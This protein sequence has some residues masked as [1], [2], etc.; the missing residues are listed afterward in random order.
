MTPD[1]H[2]WRRNLEFLRAEEAPIKPLI[3]ELTFIRNKSSWG[4]VFRRGLFEIPEEDFRR[5]AAAM[6]AQ[7]GR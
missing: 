4:F 1:F 3:E 5:I 7:L 6:H 2:P